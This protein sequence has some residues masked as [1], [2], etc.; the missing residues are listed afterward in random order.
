M[1]PRKTA[2][3]GGVFYLITFAASFPA[4]F[5]I[6]PVLDDPRYIVGAGNDT[7]ARVTL[8]CLLDIVNALACVGT[9]V[10]LFPVV[11]RQDETTALGFVTSR[12][13]EAGTIMIGVVSLLAVLTLRRDLHGTADTEALVDTGRAL[14]AVRDWTFL[15]GPSL[16]ASLN[17]LLL[18]S[19]MWRSRLVPRVIPA[20]GLVG[21]PLLLAATVAVMF[22]AFDQVSPITAVATL[23]VAAWELSVGVYLTVKGFRPSAPILATA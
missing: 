20:M 23:P 15:L 16:M 17:A 19:L 13:L 3:L 6:G 4:L 21:G 8:G 7:A 22:G 11:R 14:V 12:L 10:A 2:L 9:A 1:N 5:L 18:G